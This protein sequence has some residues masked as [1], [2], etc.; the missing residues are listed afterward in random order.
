MTLT[1]TNPVDLAQFELAAGSIPGREHVRLKRGCQDA[2]AY[3]HEPDALIA[4]V[5]DGCGSGAHSEVGAKLGARLLVNGLRS[6]LAEGT[7]P[8]RGMLVSALHADV[9]AHLEF[10]VTAMGGERSDAVADYFLFTIVGAV[11]TPR[12]ALVFSIGDGVV[13]VN[14]RRAELGPFA[15]NQPPYLAYELLCPGFVDAY[16]RVHSQEETHGLRTLILASDGATELRDQLD[17]FTR[18]DLFFRNRDAVRRRLTVVN[19]DRGD[20]RGPLVDDTSLI[21]IRRRSAP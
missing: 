16:L 3:H 13:A 5:C 11:I 18:G 15:A 2:L 21:A 17:E 9:L 10:L 12:R 7:E 8:S 4:V 19:R 1:I 14:G 6:R 20:R